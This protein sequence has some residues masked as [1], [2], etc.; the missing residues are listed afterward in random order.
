M[1][2]PFEFVDE[3]IKVTKEKY[4][5]SSQIIR[6]HK[7]K[8]EMLKIEMKEKTAENDELENRLEM[9]SKI[10]R[11]NDK[12]KFTEDRIDTNSNDKS[13]PEIIILQN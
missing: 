2:I 5:E 6:V 12:E 10:D 1:I 3:Y 9:T 4:L 8:D 13:S 11:W 7:E